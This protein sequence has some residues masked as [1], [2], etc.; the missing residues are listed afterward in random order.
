[1]ATDLG[2][3]KTILTRQAIVFGAILVRSFL[4]G[5]VY[6]LFLSFLFFF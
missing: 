6:W 1:V 2:P 4:L 5:P 3:D